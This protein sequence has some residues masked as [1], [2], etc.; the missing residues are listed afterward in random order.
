MKVY[1]ITDVSTPLL[2]QR[3]MKSQTFVIHGKA[4]KP[5]ESQ[6]Y[7][8]RDAPIVARATNHL[9][10]AGALVIDKLPTS[11]LQAKAAAAPAAVPA[12]PATPATP[13]A[14][15]ATPAAPEAPVAA[16]ATPA[17]PPPPASP[18]ARVETS[19][20]VQ[21]KGADPTSKGETPGGKVGEG[22]K[23]VAPPVKKG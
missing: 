9:V 11:Y 2:A 18:A 7:D 19:V 1:N 17:A 12:V 14:A 15:P 16:P 6:A 21:K 13:V 8:Q 5:G 10:K 4:I 20:D 22:P 23:S 3:H